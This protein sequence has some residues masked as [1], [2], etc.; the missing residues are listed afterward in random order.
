[1]IQKVAV[2]SWTRRAPRNS[3]HEGR[4]LGAT[5]RSMA[6]VTRGGQVAPTPSTPPPV[7][8]QPSHT[9]QAAVCSA[10]GWSEDARTVVRAGELPRRAGVR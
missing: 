8:D 2:I 5:R 3:H 10:R 6:Q 1:M 9:A 7:A 4:V